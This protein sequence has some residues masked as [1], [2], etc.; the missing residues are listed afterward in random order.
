MAYLISFWVVDSAKV[1][2][3]RF[4]EAVKLND[5][6]PI[7]RYQR[8]PHPGRWTKPSQGE[9]IGAFYVVRNRHPWGCPNPLSSAVCWELPP[10]I[11]EPII[12]SGL[13]KIGMDGLTSSAVG[14]LD[15]L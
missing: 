11:S 9:K 13:P 14:G 4:P 1:F 8:F 3:F 10:N 15:F 5:P 7:Q 12:L 2:T 6:K